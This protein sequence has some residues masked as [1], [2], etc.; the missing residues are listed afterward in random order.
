[1]IAELEKFPLGTVRITEQEEGS[2]W[3]IYDWQVE[4][5]PGGIVYW[6]PEMGDDV[7]VHEFSHT[8]DDATGTLDKTWVPGSE[9]P[10]TE[11]KATQLQNMYR[12]AV[13]PAASIIDEW[14]GVDVPDPAGVPRDP[15]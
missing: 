5:K 11:Q 7:L 6:N 13:D 12:L 10:V 9:C 3:A 14:N 1:M 4:N 8:E 15:W 2:H